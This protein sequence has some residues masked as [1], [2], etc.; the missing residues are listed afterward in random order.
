MS[1][2]RSES[3]RETVD[4][5][6]GAVQGLVSEGL[7][8]HLVVRNRDE[9]VVVEVPV[10]VGLLAAF[11]APMAATIAAGVALLGNCEIKVESR[12]SPATAEE[13]DEA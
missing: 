10:A 1:E 12:K 4:S 6:V 5:V 2:F 7:D 3:V 13:P 11:A 9:E 8:N